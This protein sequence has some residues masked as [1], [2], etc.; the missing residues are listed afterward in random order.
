MTVDEETKRYILELFMDH[1]MKMSALL[2]SI[3]T[4]LEEKKL[5]SRGDFDIIME[6]ARALNQQVQ[7]MGRENVA[8]MAAMVSEME[9]L[10][11]GLEKDSLEG[12]KDWKDLK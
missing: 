2:S 3:C 1:S 6:R 9:K 8:T 7:S 10:K 11:K 4:M 12:R 5:I